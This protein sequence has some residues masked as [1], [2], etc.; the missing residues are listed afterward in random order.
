MEMTEVQQK[1]FH[2]ILKSYPD[3]HSSVLESVFTL[4]IKSGTGVQQQEIV[5]PVVELHPTELK[6][7]EQTT[8]F[9]EMLDKMYHLHLIKNQDYSPSNING[10]GMIGLATRLW[11]K[12]VRIMNLLGFNIEAK[13][14]SIDTAKEPKNESLEDTFIDLANYSVI[15]RLMMLG[16]WAK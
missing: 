13:L 6:Y 4:G 16:K 3:I 11:D 14:L 7:P 15:G 2:D 9:K 12:T 5:S 1:V 8:A 10:V